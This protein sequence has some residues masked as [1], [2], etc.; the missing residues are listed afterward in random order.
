M[1]HDHGPGS[2]GSRHRGPLA[3]AFF[4][5]LGYTAAEVVGGVVFDSLALLSDAAH[6]GTDVI[7][8]GMALAAITL[9]RREGPRRRTY[10]TYRLEVLAALANGLLLFGV[11]VYVLV[12]AA[13]RWGAPPEVPGLPLLLVAAGGLAVNLVSFRLLASGAKESL[14]LKAAYLEV[15]GDLLGSVA[16]LVGAG[17]I[18]LTGWRYVD[19]VL[20]A[21]IGLFILPRAARVMGQALRILMETAPPGLDVA[22]VEADIAALPG[23]VEVHD[24]HIWTLTSGMDAASGHV[25]ADP[26]HR[27]TDVLEGVLDRLDEEYGITHA[28]IQVEEPGQRRDV[29]RHP[30]H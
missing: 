2:A 23:V 3:I 29:P 10:G 12:E 24:L 1:G 5:T 14:N 6:M 30:T 28:T 8:L 22:A 13:L 11:A 19:P 27:P 18:L 21:G 9:A 26:G 4:L 17:L 16:V 20:G 15:L 7:G 25:V